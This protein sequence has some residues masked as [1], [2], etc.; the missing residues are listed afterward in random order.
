MVHGAARPGGGG[1]PLSVRTAPYRSGPT[2]T[3]RPPLGTATLMLA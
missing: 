1:H 2:C 3:P